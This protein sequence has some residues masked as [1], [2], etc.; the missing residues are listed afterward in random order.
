LLTDVENEDQGDPYLFVQL[1]GC[2]RKKTRIRQADPPASESCSENDQ[3]ALS[4][5][6]NR[7]SMIRVAGRPFFSEYHLPD[8]PA[9]PRH[10][11]LLRPFVVAVIGHRDD[12][13][14]RSV[15]GPCALEIAIAA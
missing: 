11:L 2:P 10:N 13:R 14:C 15:A 1:A 7:W 5:R 9:D 3:V 12:L 4:P 8:L 6:S